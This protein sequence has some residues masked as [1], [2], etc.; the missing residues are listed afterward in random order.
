MRGTSAALSTTR[1]ILIWSDRH[2]GARPRRYSMGA[3]A[4]RAAADAELQA[5][6]PGGGGAIASA[7]GH[8]GATPAEI[9]ELQA[10]DGG[11]D[12]RS[13]TPV[14]D[15]YDAMVQRINTLGPEASSLDGSLDDALDAPLQ[16]AQLENPAVRGFVPCPTMQL[17]AKKC[18]AGI[19]GR[20]VNVN[21]KV[22]QELIVQYFS[23]TAVQRLAAERA[24]CDGTLQAAKLELAGLRSSKNPAA[25]HAALAKY[26]GMGEAIAEERQVLEARCGKLT[27]RARKKMGEALMRGAG[28]QEMVKL[29]DRYSRW[30]S[31]GAETNAMVQ[32]LTDRLV[33]AFPLT[34]LQQMD[35]V[36][37][38]FACTVRYTQ[39]TL[40]GLRRNRERLVNV[41]REQMIQGCTWRDPRDIAKLLQQTRTADKVEDVRAVLQSRL[42][43][44]C[45]DVIDALIPLASSTDFTAV[46]A[47]LL[48]YQ[49]YPEN[50]KDAWEALREHRDE[51]LRNAKRTFR[52]LLDTHL[53]AD[54]DRALVVYADY[55]EAVESERA[56]VVSHRKAL[57][58]NAVIELR[59]LA[60]NAE[61]TVCQMSEALDRYEQYPNV[62]AE[63]AQVL[64]IVIKRVADASE[65]TDVSMLS[66][67]LEDYAPARKYA[68]NEYE[69]LRQKFETV[70]KPMIAKMRMALTRNEPL[71]LEAVVKESQQFGPGLQKERQPLQKGLQ[72]YID[73]AKDEL[74]P[75]LSSGVFLSIENALV[76]YKDYLTATRGDV[77]LL[78]KHR[79]QL[80]ATARME[81]TDMLQSEDEGAI[82]SVLAKYESYGSA[83]AVHEAK[84]RQALKRLV[85]LDVLNELSNSDDF[86]AV[87][88]GLGTYK[89]DCETP[90][91]KSAYAAVKK[92]RDH[93]VLQA[94]QTLKKLL[95]SRSYDEVA[96][97]IQDH[98]V[99]GSFVHTER[100]D[101]EALRDYLGVIR[102][103]EELLESDDFSAID[104]SLERHAG[105]SDRQ[106]KS[107]YR[108]LQTR[109][110]QMV[111]A[112]QMALRELLG[113]VAPVAMG[114]AL[115]RYAA[116][117]RACPEEFRAVKQK[118][119]NLIDEANA[120][121][122]EAANSDDITIPAMQELITM[123]HGFPQDDVKEGMAA[124][125]AK[126]TEAIAISQEAAAQRKKRADEIRARRE[127]QVAAT[128]FNRKFDLPE[129]D[130]KT[131]IR[132]KMKQKAMEL[133]M[134]MQAEELFQMVESSQASNNAGGAAVYSAGSAAE[135]RPSTTVSEAE[136]DDVVMDGVEAVLS[137]D[138]QAAVDNFMN[139]LKKNP[140]DP[141]CAYNLSCCFALM[142]GQTD[143]AV[144]WFEL[145][146]RWGIAAH[147]EL[148]DPAN[149]PDL[150]SIARDAR[151]QLALKELRTQR[152]AH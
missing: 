28:A 25:M 78:Q 43:E 58:K 5:V 44:L 72:R 125:T 67:A 151:F 99:Y 14:D 115:T 102:E 70:V 127:R 48:K 147:D 36:I 140:Q 24:V 68:C 66:A 106:V 3:G 41:V 129:E 34:D 73:A 57:L 55:A 126:L 117:A 94:K 45:Q 18:G 40:N 38:E 77:A 144:R 120:K 29:L 74:T 6:A 131:K 114:T 75:L 49:S 39:S 130:A 85:M 15:E 100:T 110:D 136:T 118:R 143:A 152:A 26:N 62:R 16:S 122:L 97:G 145:C 42:E 83:V 31:L 96:A 53:L 113:Y 89:D 63:R 50:V 21:P 11:Y 52:A 86:A 91:Q 87:L 90:N 119:Q 133:R 150:A 71:E 111:A 69:N 19:I 138:L 27:D 61:S 7:Q 35:A 123:Y 46:E 98:E 88:D 139:S 81:L 103:L 135:P 51:L 108:R 104:A 141:V 1:L 2:A 124:L 37:N 10:A 84:L 30:P 142:E 9:A 17:F 8:R 128:L 54:I 56:A 23:A 93:L 60:V 134:K 20:Q 12:S 33:A 92:R 121:L 13:E 101:L 149:D 80:L 79:D 65:L 47:A 109:K 95:S 107:A 146:V 112:V 32:Y 137:N 64:A 59:G 132:N 116:Y 76:K 4:S 82:K 22:R 148:D 105:M